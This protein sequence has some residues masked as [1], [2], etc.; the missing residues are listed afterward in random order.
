MSLKK[1]IV[2]G[3]SSGIGRALAKELARQGYEVGLVARRE[4]LLKSLAAEIPTKT[5]IKVID[6]R[7]LEKTIFL[8]D[9]L[10]L[11]MGGLDLMVINAGI[12]R[13]NPNLDWEPELETVRVNLLGFMAASHIAAKYFLAAGTGHIVGISSISVLRGNGRS[14]AYS[15]SK[16]FMS[17]YLAGLRQRFLGTAIHVTDIRPGFV[18]TAML[19]KKKKLFW[20]ASPERAAEQIFNAIRKKKK[21][22]YVTK[23][24]GIAALITPFIP[25][26]LYDWAYRKFDK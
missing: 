15:A 12:F 9:E 3:A 13:E 10:I 5:Y 21:T 25:D 22:V 4:D 24:W 2:T 11:Q 20:C 8:L 1:A 19:S 26:R 6:L 16:I 17:N 14:P 23:R 18:D 7:H